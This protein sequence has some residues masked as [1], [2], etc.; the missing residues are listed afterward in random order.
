[1]PKWELGRRI[2]SYSFQ[3]GTYSLKQQKSRNVPMGPCDKIDGNKTGTTTLAAIASVP[4]LSSIAECRK[5]G[6][7]VMGSKAGI[8]I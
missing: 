2:A 3:P 8:A 6:R 1:M 7:N 5:A 4:R